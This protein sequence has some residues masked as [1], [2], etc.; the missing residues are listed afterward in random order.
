[1]RFRIAVED[2]ENDH[3][4]A[5]ALDLPGCFSSAQ[6]SEGAIAQAPERIAEHLAWLSKHG[7]F[8][9]DA[10]LPI[11]VEIVEQF[12]S[13]ESAEEKGYIVNALFEDDRRPLGFWDIEA[14]LRLL[15]WSRHDLLDLVQGV[16]DERLNKNIG[17]ETFGSVAG[18]LRHIAIAENWY[19]DRM[20][21]GLERKLLHE[22]AFEM[23][24]VVREN[25]QQQ[26]VKLIGDHRIV[27]ESG[28]NWSG[29]KVLRRMLW[30]E[31][32]HTRHVAQIL[33]EG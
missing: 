15:A 6:S 18:I 33:E 31:R 10:N 25:A 5:Y 7:V 22:D 14:T 8:S 1:M 19:F 16:K 11:E 9:L 17:G 21:F 24:A 4:V 32:D 28:E 2:I 27:N 30:H 29:R 12:R 13:Y 20:G 23:L 3:W 26:L